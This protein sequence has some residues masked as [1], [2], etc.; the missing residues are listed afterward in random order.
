MNKDKPRGYWKSLLKDWWI[1]IILMFMVGLR[2]FYYEPFSSIFN[3]LSVYTVIYLIYRLG[4]WIKH[5]KKVK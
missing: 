3:V 2:S 1:I 4:Y 5:R